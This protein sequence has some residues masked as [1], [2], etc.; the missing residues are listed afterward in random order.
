MSYQSIHTRFF[1]R[2]GAKHISY[3]K[4]VHNRWGSSWVCIINTPRQTPGHPCPIRFYH[5]TDISSRSNPSSSYVVSLWYWLTSSASLVYT[6]TSYCAYKRQSLTMW[7]T[8][9]RHL[10][11]LSPRTNRSWS[12][13]SSLRF[14]RAFSASNCKH[15]IVLFWYIHNSR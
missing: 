10:R 12:P 9:P 3:G 5:T 13:A 15:V 8:V 2:L 6:F 14:S 11:V 1:G 4:C 7:T